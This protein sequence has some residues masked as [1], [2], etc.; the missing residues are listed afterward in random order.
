MNVQRLVLR[1]VANKR[2]EKYEIYSIYN[3]EF[4]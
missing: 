4:N 2:K 3:K 1:D